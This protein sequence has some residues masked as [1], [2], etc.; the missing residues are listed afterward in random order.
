MCEPESDVKYTSAQVN[1]LWSNF[2]PFKILFSIILPFISILLD[3]L[4]CNFG[5]SGFALSWL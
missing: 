1:N 5:V 3:K 4:N 2:V